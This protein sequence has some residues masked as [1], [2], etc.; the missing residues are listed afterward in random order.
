MGRPKSVSQHLTKMQNKKVSF[1]EVYDVFAIRIILDTEEANE[2]A[3]IWRTYGIVTDF[4]QPN[5][6]RLR[7]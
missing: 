1:E 5:P 7:D 6:D 4:Y 2:K 3:D